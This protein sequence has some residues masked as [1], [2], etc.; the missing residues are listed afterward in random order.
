[1][2]LTISTT[3]N[4]ADDL[5]YLLHKHPA[6]VQAFELSVGT[7]HVFYPELGAGRCIAAL[8][9]PTAA[10]RLSRGSP[11]AA[12]PLRDATTWCLP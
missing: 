4:P 5:G 8:L 6:R 11:A 2:L 1:M 12:I 10:E 3:T 9:A 7:A